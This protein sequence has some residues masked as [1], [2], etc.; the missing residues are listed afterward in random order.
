MFE[1]IALQFARSELAI[2]GPARPGHINR[3]SLDFKKAKAELDWSPM[4]TIEDGLERT[5]D[6]FKRNSV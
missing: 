1:F 2:H 6:W 4:V 3:I 5:V